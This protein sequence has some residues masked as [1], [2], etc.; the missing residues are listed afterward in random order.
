MQNTGSMIDTFCCCWEIHE[1]RKGLWTFFLDCVLRMLIIGWAYKLQSRGKFEDIEKRV[2]NT[3]SISVKPWPNGLTSRRKTV[4]ILIILY[5]LQVF[6]LRSTCVSF[7]HPLALTCDDLH[8]LWSSSN[9][10]ASWRKFFTVLPPNASSHKLNASHL[11]VCGITGTCVNL[12]A[13]LRIRLTTHR[14]S[15]RKFWFANLCWLASTCEFVWP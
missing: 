14:K 3:I 6:D 4:F 5:I 11:Y 13:D 12:R 7:G 9:S 2:S 15:A 8:W 1:V 10:H